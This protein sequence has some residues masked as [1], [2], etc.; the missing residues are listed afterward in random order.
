MNNFTN[1]VY[2]LTENNDAYQKQLDALQLPDLAI[3]QMPDEACILLASPPLAAK[4]LNDFPHLEWMQS[5]YAGVDALATVEKSDFLLT[6][7]KGIF[8]QQISEY[9]LGYLIQHHRH[10]LHY[11]ESQNQAKWVPKPY[12]S[13]SALTLL[14]LGTGSIGSH[15]AK[16]TQAFGIKVIGINRSG[17][18]AMHSPFAETYHIQE[19]ESVLSRVDVIVNTL[20]STPDT[21]HILNSQSLSHCRSALLFNVG[22]GNAICESGLL[23]AIENQS[24]THAYL[25]VFENEPLEAQHPFWHHPAITVTPHIAAL[26]FPEQVVEIFAENYQRWRDGFSLI[27][28]VDLEKGY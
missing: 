23:S 3:T 13:L 21:L 10:F 14:V 17:I 7:V 27:N 28:E 2:L 22:R 24:I 26:S 25:D 12:Q 4:K 16:T 15:L 8:G 19:L 18:P 11:Q 5:V 9:V 20:P 1:K 6:N